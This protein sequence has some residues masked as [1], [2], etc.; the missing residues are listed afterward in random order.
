[1]ALDDAILIISGEDDPLG[2]RLACDHTYSGSLV[3]IERYASDCGLGLLLD[4]LF[5]LGCSVPMSEN[6][7][8]LFDLFL[9]FLVRIDCAGE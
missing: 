7:S 6:E 4:L 9:E 8:A 5:G 1:M 2:R 3:S